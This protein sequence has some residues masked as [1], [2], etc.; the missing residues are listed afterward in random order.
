[1]RRTG[2]GRLVKSKPKWEKVD[3]DWLQHRDEVHALT[4]HLIEMFPDAR[5]VVTPHDNGFMV[6]RYKR[7]EP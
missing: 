3:Q 7:I 5:I 2:L 1:M 6:R 4:K